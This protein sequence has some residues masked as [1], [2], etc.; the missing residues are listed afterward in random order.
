[1]KVFIGV[2]YPI[3]TM[4]PGSPIEI[5]P[6]NAQAHRVINIPFPA[7]VKGYGPFQNIRVIVAI[8]SFVRGIAGETRV[9]NW[10][11]L[12]EIGYFIKAGQI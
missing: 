5:S 11:F 10:I 12:Q 2:D 3:A 4:K 1:M 9:L 8:K 6:G 7:G